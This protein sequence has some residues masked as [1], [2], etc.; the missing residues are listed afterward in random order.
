MNSDIFMVIFFFKIKINAYLVD[1]PGL[2]E[3]LL[4]GCITEPKMTRK[5]DNNMM[6]NMQYVA[7]LH[8]DLIGHLIIKSKSRTVLKEFNLLKICNNASY[9]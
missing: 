8:K 9:W 6:P 1:G 4:I 2:L 7:K 3:L 5:D